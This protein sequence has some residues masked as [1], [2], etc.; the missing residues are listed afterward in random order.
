MAQSLVNDAEQIWLASA[1]AR[2]QRRHL[3][4]GRRLACRPSRRRV[5]LRG[6][7]TST[8]KPPSSTCSRP[9]TQPGIGP[10]D[11]SER[12]FLADELKLGYVPVD[13]DSHRR[14]AHARICQRRLCHRAARQHPRRHGQLRHARE[15]S[16][17]LAKPFRPRDEM[18][19]SPQRRRL[20]ACRLRRRPHRCHDAPDAPPWVGPTGYE[21]GNTWQYS[22]MIP[23]DYPRLIAAMGGRQRRRPAPRQ[24]FLE[25][26]LLG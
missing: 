25:A 3:R 21:E 23:F 7:R 4:H 13:N 8:L 15:A 14:F 11:Q 20:L 18:D 19:S 2:R 9:H 24:V 22:F 17:E 26:H 12:P 5:C 6:V 1:L 10:H 16:R